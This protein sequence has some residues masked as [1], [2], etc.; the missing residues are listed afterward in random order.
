MAWLCSLPHNALHS[1]GIAVKFSTVQLSWHYI[2]LS[3]R[4]HAKCS[5]SEARV[6]SAELSHAQQ[7]LEW[8]GRVREAE[9][10]AYSKQQQVLKQLTESRNKVYY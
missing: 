7:R 9:K 1:P 3:C 10:V 5:Q 4:V 6:K 2:I 8:E